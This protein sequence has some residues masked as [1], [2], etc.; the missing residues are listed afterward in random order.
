MIW[1]TRGCRKTKTTNPKAAN[2]N[3][4]HNLS[5]GGHIRDAVSTLEP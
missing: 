1:S 2:Q 3:L 4:A 5:Q